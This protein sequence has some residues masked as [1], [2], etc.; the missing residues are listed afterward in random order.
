MIALYNT[1][2]IGA[3]LLAAP[4]ALVP[5][6]LVPRWRAGLGQ[7]LR[8][9][10][11]RARPSVWVHAAS[12]GEVEAA[13]PLIRALEA[14]GL[15]VVATS[16]SLT[17]RARLRETLPQLDPRLAPLD[18][19]WL[20]R[21]SVR[22]ARVRVLVLI[23]TELW[24][25][26]IAAT[27]AAGGRVVIASGRVSDRSYAR[28]RRLRVLFAAVLGR[29]SRIAAQSEE[30]AQRF[31]ALGALPERCSVVGD[32]KLDRDPPAPAPEALRTALG[33][34]PF[35][36]AGSTH[37]GE[38]E[39]LLGAWR[40]LRA[41]AAPG[42]RLVLVPRHPDR[43]EAVLRAARAAGENAALRSKGAASADVVVVD[44]L[45]ELAAIYPLAELIFAG[46]T[47]VPVGGHNLL[48]PVRAGRVVVCGPQLHN[49][50]TQVQLLA[51][52]GVLVRIATARDL[53][54][55]LERL[56]L[57]PARN[58]PARRARAALAEH[59]GTV[60]RVASQ[61]CEAY[62]AALAGA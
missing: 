7:R 28:Y 20:T 62:D 58:A 59:R 25:N 15:D 12:V 22:R 19:P 40:E 29:V 61:V 14:R 35:L 21:A 31:C 17:G 24:P 45:G 54:P 11:A 2:L 34:G 13:L 9:L 43:A 48:E 33:P 55:A 46:G 23:E 18:L 49:Q 57:D 30:S 56:W 53:A 3:L 47:L 6:A 44:T 41:R 32:L 4:F 26:A 37:A 50:R 36:V 52:F 16:L 42:L 60:E 38:E 39:V 5:L 10:P 8:A 51:P 27:S 1:L